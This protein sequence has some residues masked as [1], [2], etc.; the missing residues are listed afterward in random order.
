MKKW[1][2]YEAQ[3]DYIIEI[4]RQYIS[5]ITHYCRSYKLY[6]RIRPA[7]GL[8]RFELPKW[9]WTEAELMKLNK[10]IDELLK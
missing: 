3:N 9:V 4:D 2:G 10:F 6:Y 7:D 5:R 1:I 8:V